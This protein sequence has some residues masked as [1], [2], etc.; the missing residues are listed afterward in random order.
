LILHQQQSCASAPRA[1]AARQ[2]GR[3]HWQKQEYSH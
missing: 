2:Y 3:A 1:K